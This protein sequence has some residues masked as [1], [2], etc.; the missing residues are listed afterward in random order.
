[1]LFL[2]GC[3]SYNDRV[4]PYLKQIGDGNYVQAAK[5]L[6]KNSLLSKPRNRLLFLMEKGKVS[7]LE[8]DYQNSNLYFNEADRLLESGLGGVVDGAVGTLVNPM[9]Q[10]Y[11]GEDFEKFMIHYYKALNY[12]YLHQTEDAIVEARRISI[13]TQ[14][15]GDKFNDKE[16]RY[17]KDAFS[18]MLQ[19]L[20]YE[21]ASDVNN[22][23]IAYRNAADVYLAS[24]DSIYYGVKIPNTLKEDLLRTAY[25]NGFTSEV[26]KYEKAFNVKYHYKKTS[27]GGELIFFWENGIVPAKQQKEFFFSLIKD[28][29]GDMVFSDGNIIVPFYN[30]DS[31]KVRSAS[32]QSLRVTYPVYVAKPSYFKTAQLSD[33]LGSVTFEK[34]EDINVLAVKTLDQR[35]AKEMGKTLSRLA[36][37]KSAEYILSESGK[38]A[39]K[40]GKDDALL[41]GL[42]YGMQLYSLLS[43]KSDTRNWQSLP[44]EIN[45]ARIPLKKGDNTISL[46]LQGANGQEEVKTIHVNGTGG[47]KFYNYATLR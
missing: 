7:H 9:T 5:E 37:K 33:T 16:N 32:V 27:E 8:G 41:T 36:V 47:L 2:F 4:L 46:R 34:A 3:A 42:G 26:G 23:F 45:Y 20:L 35:F 10:V 24:P 25:Q 1:M 12:L 6:D 44:D 22:A 43:E 13:Q 40:N 17:S 29:N 30:Y 39:G 21:S 38:N 15:Q 31:K 19:G 14:E 18:L 11:K 28:S